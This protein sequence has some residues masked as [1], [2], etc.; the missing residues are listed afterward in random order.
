MGF[1]IVPTQPFGFN[2]L[3]GKLMSL[4]ITSKKIRDCEYDD[5]SLDIYVVD[6]LEDQVEGSDLFYLKMGYISVTP[7][8]LNVTDYKSLKKMCEIFE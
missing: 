1:V 6:D 2:F 3:G 8:S 7:L 5:G 4:L